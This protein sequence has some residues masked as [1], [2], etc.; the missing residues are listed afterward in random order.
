MS[1]T[2]EKP[3]E[4][5]ICNKTFNRS[6]NLT[7]H[8]R[9]HTGEKPY[10]CEICKKAFS[11][12]SA[13]ATHKRIHTGEKPYACDICEKTFSNKS[14]LVQ[15]KRM[16]TGEKP[17][18]CDICLKSYSRNSQLSRHNKSAAHLNIQK[19]LL[20][21]SSTNPTNFVDC[22]ENIKVESIKEEINEEESVEDPLYILQNKDLD[23]YNLDACVS[24]SDN[25]DKNNSV[26]N[27]LDNVEVNNMDEE[28]N[29]VVENVEEN[30]NYVEGY[31]IGQGNVNFR[32]L[33]NLS[34]KEVLAFFSS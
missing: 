34:V 11:N 21:D 1:H 4:C 26:N 33:E 24:R 5:E 9:V 22:G 8:Q 20:E 28:V 10:E 30:V 16:H 14:H 31:V 3:Y 12:N 15:H 29:N 6:A 17:Y 2:D 19:S 7:K 13:L 23:N 25:S 18:S 27:L 32:A